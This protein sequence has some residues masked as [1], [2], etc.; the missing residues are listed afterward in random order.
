[1]N[2]YTPTI[3]EFHVGFEYE[4]SNT[5]EFTRAFTLQ[6]SLT[7]KR[8]YKLTYPDPYYGYD[9]TKLFKKEIRVKCL[10]EDDILSLGFI[11]DGREFINSDFRISLINDFDLIAINQIYEFETSF[12]GKV[13]NKSELVVLLKQIGI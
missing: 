3:E 1:M 5:F 4:V 11:K 9:L 13:K 2:Y 10:D 6:E 8:W 12:F 7:E